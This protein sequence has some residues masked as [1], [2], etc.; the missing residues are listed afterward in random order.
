MGFF[1]VCCLRPP[2]LL[3]N[4]LKVAS[5][6]VVKLEVSVQIRSFTD[7]RDQPRGTAGLLA[8]WVAGF[9]GCIFKSLIHVP[10]PAVPA[11]QWEEDL[12]SG[13]KVHHPPAYGQRYKAWFATRVSASCLSPLLLCTPVPNLT[14]SPPCT[15][16]LANSSIISTFI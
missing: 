13:H 6:G 5:L 9:P 3:G 14:L 10:D 7:L 11:L 8:L 2:G 15:T 12:A 4:D 1:C 16:Y